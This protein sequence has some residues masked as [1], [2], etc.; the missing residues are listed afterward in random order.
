MCVEEHCTVAD[1]QD[2]SRVQQ[3]VDQFKEYHISLVDACVVAVAERLN[4]R[5][6]ATLDP[7]LM[8]NFSPKHEPSNKP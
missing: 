8:C 5:L 4:T 3:I 2:L 7:E 1:I 6:L